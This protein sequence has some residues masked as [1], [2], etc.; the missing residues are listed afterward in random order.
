MCSQSKRRLHLDFDG[1][2]VHVKNPFESFQTVTMAS[3]ATTTV[4]TTAANET[5][6]P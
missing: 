5:M 4:A 6:L 3:H 2:A 1:A